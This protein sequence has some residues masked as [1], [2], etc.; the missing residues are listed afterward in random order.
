MLS[1]MKEVNNYQGKMQTAGQKMK[2]LG[3]LCLLVELL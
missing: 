1:I 3:W 2:K